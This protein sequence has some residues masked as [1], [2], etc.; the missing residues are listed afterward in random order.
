VIEKKVSALMTRLALEHNTAFQLA[1]GDN[2]YTK[3]I[4]NLDDKRFQVIFLIKN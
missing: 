3:G 1:I 4:Q 2:F